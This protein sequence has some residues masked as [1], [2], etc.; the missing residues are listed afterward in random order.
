M[1]TP[2]SS[3]ANPIIPGVT[4]P[5]SYS[6]PAGSSP[7]HPIIPGTQ[8]NA[9]QPNAQGNYGTTTANISNPSSTTTNNPPAVT[10]SSAAATDLANKQ[11]QVNQLNTDTANHQAIVSASNLPP[12]PTSSDA[13][14]TQPGSAN[15]GSSLD[16]QVNDLL[17]SFDTSS[18][19]VLSDATSQEN[20]LGTEAQQTQTAL[21]TAAS[22]ALYQLNAIAQGAYPLSPAESSI[23]NATTAQFQQ[24]LQYQTQANQAYTGQ[25]TE[26]MASLGIETS[27]PTEAFGM[28]NASITKGTQD[29]TNINS[30][31][32]I[33]LGNLQL[34]FQ[35]QDF[36]MVQGAWDETSKYMEDRVTSLT[37]M[38]KNIQDAATAQVDELQKSAQMTITSYIDSDKF[39]FSVA[40]AA[41]KNGIAQGTLD[42]KTAQD[43][44]SDALKAQ[45]NAI[46][47][48]KANQG[49][50]AEKT[51]DAITNFS[52]TFVPGATMSDGTP[53]VDT[54]GYINPAAWKAAINDAPAE[55]LSRAGFIKNFGGKV[56]TKNAKAYGLTP[57]EIRSISGALPAT[58]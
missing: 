45:S 48:E 3:P 38:Q 58:S 15:D 8:A 44:R 30:S 33:A 9:P 25:M 32:A 10:T 23:L 34:G 1:P 7:A 14:A 12:A 41:I 52:A 37:T 55:G 40:D 19:K 24:A 31:M 35:K 13:S 26:A 51:D 20:T 56:D 21:D 57:V 36:D 28:I 39:D 50:E 42:E 11:N 4:P 43:L 27:A 29:I 6:G 46:E 49:T 5:S 2:G 18:D 17:N 54:N 16:S 22:S 47:Q 53:T